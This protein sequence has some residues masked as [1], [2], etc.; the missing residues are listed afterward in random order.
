MRSNFLLRLLCREEQDFEYARV[1]QEELQRCAE[2]AQRRELDDEVSFYS[3]LFAY[4]AYFITNLCI[5][6]YIFKSNVYLIFFYSTQ[7]SKK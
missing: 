7:H 1:I 5:N 3:H 6:I 4:I 2:E